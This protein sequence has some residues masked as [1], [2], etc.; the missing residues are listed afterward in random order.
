MKIRVEMSVCSK[1]A[2]QNL[3]RNQG[4]QLGFMC[5]ALKGTLGHRGDFRG[6]RAV[7]DSDIRA[8]ASLARR[9]KQRQNRSSYQIY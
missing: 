7:A 3:L 9:G 2:K 8:N 5:L 6:L 4:E 1:G